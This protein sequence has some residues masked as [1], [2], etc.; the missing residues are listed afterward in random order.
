MDFIIEPQ[1]IVLYGDN[2]NVLAEVT[3]I[4]VSDNVININHTFVDESLRGQQIASKLLD[5]LVTRMT[6]EDKKIIPSCSYAISWFNKHPEYNNL[7]EK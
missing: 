6:E 1:R 2:S 3:F 4:N 5:R 7:L